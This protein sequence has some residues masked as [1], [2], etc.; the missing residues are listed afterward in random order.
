MAAAANNVSQP[1][2]SRPSWPRARRLLLTGATMALLVGA[3]SAT[4]GSSPI[5]SELAYARCMR[6][7]GVTNF[8][9][10]GSDGSFPSFRPAASKQMFDAAQRACQ[11]LLPHAGGG[12]GAETRG[13]QQKIALALR[14]ARCMRAHGFPTYPDPVPGPASS[15]GSGTRFAG[16]GIDTKSLRFQT[17]EA[18]CERHARQA[19]GLPAPK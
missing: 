1:S 10:P 19:L 7:H 12:G 6:A 14:V 15:Q 13:D 17:A 3:S 18:N 2:G 11:H 8:P 16:T 5:R 9:D 4:A